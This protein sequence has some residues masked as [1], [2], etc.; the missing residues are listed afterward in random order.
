MDLAFI[1]AEVVV[2]AA[3]G[4]VMGAIAHF[5][6]APEPDAKG[7]SLQTRTGASGAVLWI[8]LIAVR[9]G[10]DVLGAHLGAHLLSSTG[11][12]LIMI[13]VNRAARA[14]VLDRRI[15]SHVRAGA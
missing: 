15:P 10:M 11:M 5:R 2:S 1:G 8:V 4:L 13:A 14:A 3:A 6:A 12:V 7:R 9:I